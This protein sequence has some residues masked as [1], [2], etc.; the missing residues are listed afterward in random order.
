M[1]GVEWMLGN[2]STKIAI[3]ATSERPKIY[4]SVTYIFIRIYVGYPQ[5]FSNALGVN[6]LSL[7]TISMIAPAATKP[8]VPVT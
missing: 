5:F 7:A 3:I 1:Q 4:R 6:K 8:N 2:Q